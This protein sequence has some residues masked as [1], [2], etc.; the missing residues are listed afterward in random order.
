MC[1]KQR[2]VWFINKQIGNSSKEIT[3][4][5]YLFWDAGGVKGRTGNCVQF[6]YAE[7][8][9]DSQNRRHEYEHLY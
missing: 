7:T 3:L 8:W 1:L 5:L 9:P 2:I 4:T 6:L